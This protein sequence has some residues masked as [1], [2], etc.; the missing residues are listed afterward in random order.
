MLETQGFNCRL[1][2]VRDLY[3]PETALRFL[4]HLNRVMEQMTATPDL[5]TS[6]F[7]LLTQEE[8]HQ[9]LVE[10]N[11]AS[12]PESLGQS[13]HTMFE[14]QAEKTPSATAVECEGAA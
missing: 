8:L 6:D 3:T 14:Q 5:R 4:K 11:G 9:V 13:V 10:W 1:S 2:Y 7:S 12:V